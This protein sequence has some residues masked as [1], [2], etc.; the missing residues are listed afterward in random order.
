MVTMLADVTADAIA[1]LDIREGQHIHALIKT[2]TQRRKLKIIEHITRGFRRAILKLTPL[3]AT[4]ASTAG[5]EPPQPRHP[6]LCGYSQKAVTVKRS[7][8]GARRVSVRSSAAVGCSVIPQSE[9]GRARRAVN[10]G[11]VSPFAPAALR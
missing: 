5:C 11:A 6:T 3:H 7:D 2:E 8:T 1:Q 9:H 4:A 10:D